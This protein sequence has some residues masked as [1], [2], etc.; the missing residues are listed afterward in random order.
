MNIAW[1]TA[2]ILALLLPGFFFIRGIG[3]AEPFSRDATPR[4][5]IALL[6]LAVLISVL[7][8]AVGL[9]SV[10]AL[11]RPCDLGSVLTLAAGQL[12]TSQALDRVVASIAPFTWNIAAYFLA[13]SLLGLLLGWLLGALGT[14][15]PGLAR[16]MFEHAW[17]HTLHD[18]RYRS[19]VYALTDVVYKDKRVLYVGEIERFGIRQDG[20]FSFLILKNASRGKL[21][22]DDDKDGMQWKPFKQDRVG[23]LYL[24]G[25]SIA[26]LFVELAELPKPAAHDAGFQREAIEALERAA[27][28]ASPAPPSPPS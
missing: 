3:L 1:S 5:P 10:D 13:T 20:R 8:H 6:A 15:G 7:I 9:S 26:N 18:P 16:A 21:A 28:A 27:K 19:I 24:D 11:Q 12:G 25:E 22:A 4:S 14:R 17:L 2:A 23:V